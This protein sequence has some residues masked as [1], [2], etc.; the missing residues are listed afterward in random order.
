MDE[1]NTVRRCSCAQM[2]EVALGESEGRWG[3]VNMERQGHLLCA[4]E[5]WKPARR[6]AGLYCAD[7]TTGHRVR[8]DA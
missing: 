5:A 3:P 4:E 2:G 1:Q 8:N 7:H 6:T